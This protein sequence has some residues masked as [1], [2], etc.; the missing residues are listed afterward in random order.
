MVM[1]S[2]PETNAREDPYNM[3]SGQSKRNR[4]LDVYICRESHALT[5]GVQEPGPNAAANLPYE[6]AET[7]RDTLCLGIAAER[8]LRLRDAN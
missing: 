4:T 1:I 5:Y 7:G 8:V 2:P 6:N 3:V